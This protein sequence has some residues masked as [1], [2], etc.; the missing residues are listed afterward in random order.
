MRQLEL[1]GIP[2]CQVAN[3]DDLGQALSSWMAMQPWR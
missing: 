2:V 1:M 3:G